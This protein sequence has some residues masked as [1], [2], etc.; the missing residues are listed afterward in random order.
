MSTAPQCRPMQWH[1][2][3]SAPRIVTVVGWC[4]DLPGVWADGNRFR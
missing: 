4:A 1:W 3:S 2:T